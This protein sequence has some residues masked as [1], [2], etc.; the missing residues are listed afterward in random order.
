MVLVTLVLLCAILAPI[1]A[2][3]DPYTINMEEAL[4]APSGAHPLGTDVFGR[5]VMSRLIYGARPA[6][7]SSRGG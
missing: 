1:V 2:P 4:Q 6:L 3:Y 5:D 7:H